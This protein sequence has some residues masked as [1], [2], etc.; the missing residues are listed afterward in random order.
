MLITKAQNNP[1]LAAAIQ[2]V[3]EK[4]VYIYPS[5]SFEVQSGY[6][7]IDVLADDEEIIQFLSQ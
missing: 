5:S 3:K 2:Q 1:R 4:G 7:N 6:L